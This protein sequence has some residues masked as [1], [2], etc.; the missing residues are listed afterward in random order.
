MVEY[1]A[2]L[3]TGV[4]G[5]DSI[6]DGG[7]VEGASYIIQ[8][9]PG[10]G[11]TILSNQIAFAQAAKGLPVLYVT[12]LAE[13]HDRLFQSLSTLEFFDKRKLGASIK[14]VGVFQCLRDDGL[15]A[16]VK[17][18]REETQ[19]QNAKLLV[20]DG[21]LNARDRAETD[22]DVKTFVASIQSQAAFIGCTVMFLAS[23]RTP[24][25]NPEHTMV[26]GVIDLS[27]E[28]SGER[29]YR[30][31]QVRKFRGSA[32]LRGFHQ[33]EISARGITVYPRLEACLSRPSAADRPEAG[34]LK[35][36]TDGLDR[37]IGGGL[38]AGSVTVLMGPPGSGKTSLSLAFLNLASAAQPG[39]FFGFFETPARLAMKAAALGFDIAALTSSGAAEIIWNPLTENLLDKLAHQLLQAI[40]ARGV[41][42]LVIDGAGGFERATPNPRRLVEFFASLSNELRALG[43]TTLMTWEM[44]QLAGEDG[45]TPIPEFS[46]ILD[47]LFAIRHQ[48]SESELK[49]IISVLKIRDNLFDEP[50]AQLLLSQEGLSVVPLSAF[51]PSGGRG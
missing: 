36:G 40:R 44:R 51:A 28:V 11:K 23:T 45:T 16:V 7:L 43:V 48:H 34:C 10:A 25:M 18:I 46:E 15:D 49:R 13:T 5:L 33:F 35:S 1:L 19:R 6:L 37:L 41:K 32:A 24:E 30:R 47:N 31:L 21:L 14:Y 3:Q 4:S 27:D 8:G 42:R 9:S 26:D 12:L 50:E 29:A 17:L 38:G 20:F 2:R 39:L 22:L